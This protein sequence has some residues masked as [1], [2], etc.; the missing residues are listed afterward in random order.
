VCSSDLWNRFEI[1]RVYHNIAIERFR[2]T[3]PINELTCYPA[4]AS[5]IR[6]ADSEAFDL[7]QLFRVLVERGKKYEK[8]VKS[9]Q[10]ASQM[11]DY[12]SKA[13]SHERDFMG[14]N[15]NNI[16]YVSSV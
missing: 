7:S 6:S 5:Q 11:F 1:V 9:L 8:I 14:R 16:V 3:K 15:N 12:H 2:G 4:G 13:L 10:G